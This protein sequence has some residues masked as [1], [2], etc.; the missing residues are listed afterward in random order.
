MARR[1]PWRSI[2][3]KPTSLLMT[4]WSIVVQQGGYGRVIGAAY[5]GHADYYALQ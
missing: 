1:M 5:L 3:R 4:A 2:S